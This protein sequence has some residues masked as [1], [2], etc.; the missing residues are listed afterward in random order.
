MKFI[1]VFFLACLSVFFMNLNSISSNENYNDLQEKELK[2]SIN[3]G[4]SIYADFCMRCHLPNGEGVENTYPPLAKSNWLKNKREASI[5]SVK[6]GLSGEIIVNGKT[7][8]NRMS[9]MGLSDQEVADVMNY[10]MHNFGNS[11]YNLKQVT[12]AEVSKLEKK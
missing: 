2:Q 10:I 1:L 11:D 3:D 6:F 9:A 8:N 4:K 12:K 5:K 7:Y